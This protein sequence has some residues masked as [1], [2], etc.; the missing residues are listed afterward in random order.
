[1]V[2]KLRNNDNSLANHRYG[3]SLSSMTMDARTKMLRAAER[4]LDASPDRDIT[5]REVCE[6][7]GVGQ[8]VLYRQFGDKNGLLRALVDYG[9]ERYLAT[10][11]AAAPSDDPVADL[12]RGW[13]THV[14]FALEHPAVYR[15]MFSPSFDEVPGAAAEAMD[16]LRGVLTRCAEA[17]LLAVDV[18]VAAQVIMAANVGV[19]LSLVTQPDRYANPQL[20]RRVRDAVHRDLLT[21][22]AFAQAPVR[23]AGVAATANQLAALLAA[24][25][26]LPLTDAERGLLAQWLTAL[27]GGGG[28]G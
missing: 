21:D 15:L 16:I 26:E 25:R 14:A 27:A 2:R 17:G 22:E 9:F 20:S 10:K 6:A 24:Q 18:D 12:R 4:L 7:A 11:R 5:T 28:A 8:P 1:M 23:P 19:A 3:F 13:D